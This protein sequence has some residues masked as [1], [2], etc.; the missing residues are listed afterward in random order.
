MR[1]RRDRRARPSF[2]RVASDEGADGSGVSHALNIVSAHGECHPPLVPRMSHLSKSKV[3]PWTNRIVTRPL[4][5]SVAQ[6]FARI[7]MKNAQHSP[8][9]SRPVSRSRSRWLV[10]YETR[11]RTPRTADRSAAGPGRSRAPAR[12]AA[13]PTEPDA[14]DGQRSRRRVRDLLPGLPT[15]GQRRAR[16][17]PDDVALRTTQRDETGHAGDPR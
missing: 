4:K 12:S 11:H 15:L 7:K 5:T 1:A 6:R 3:N 14:R 10:L 16:S 13:G 8:V 2:E 17:R 9:R